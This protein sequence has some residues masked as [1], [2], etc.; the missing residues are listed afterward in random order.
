MVSVSL[1]FSFIWDLTVLSRARFSEKDW[2]KTG[3][4][5]EFL[6]MFGSQT[7]MESLLKNDSN[8]VDKG[9]SSFWSAKRVRILH[10]IYWNWQFRSL[11]VHFPLS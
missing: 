11:D 8:Q 4:Y 1:I 5:T 10:V 6:V 3:S 9:C 2:T 7:D